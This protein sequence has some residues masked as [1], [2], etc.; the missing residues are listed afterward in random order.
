MIGGTISKI[1]IRH[2]EVFTLSNF[3]Q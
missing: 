1:G 2:K 3:V